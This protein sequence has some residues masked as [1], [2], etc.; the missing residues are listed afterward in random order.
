MELVRGQYTD[1][2]PAY[3][4]GA[5]G[6]LTPR[7][8]TL[9]AGAMLDLPPAHQ[10]VRA[11]ALFLPPAWSSPARLRA[12]ALAYFGAPGMALSLVV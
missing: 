10:I 7:A 8:L 12:P 4:S 6:L 3:E 11:G 5:P 9:R 1:L 2:A